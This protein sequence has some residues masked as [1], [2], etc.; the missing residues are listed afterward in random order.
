MKYILLASLI[1]SSC[2]P[3][4]AQDNCQFNDTYRDLQVFIQIKELQALRDIKYK[5]E[6]ADFE[7]RME[8]YR[9]KVELYK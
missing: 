5:Q 1:L 9:Y 7:R 3:C 4:A 8:S 6:Q 2:H